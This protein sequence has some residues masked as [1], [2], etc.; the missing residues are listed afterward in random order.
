MRTV[1]V[2]ADRIPG[3]VERFSERHGPS[4][5]KRI[6]GNLHV[7]AADG[8]W[9]TLS[10][11]HPLDDA[12]V[13]T[14]DT[15][16]EAW[17][18]SAA[19]VPPTAVI[20]V[21]R[22][23]FL[24]AVVDGDQVEGRAGRRHVQGRT[25]AGGW[26]Q[27]RFARRRSQQADALVDAAADYATTWILPRLPVELLVLGGDKPLVAGVLSDSRLQPLAGLTRGRTLDVG[28][29]TSATLR[30]LPKLLREVSIDV[31]DVDRDGSR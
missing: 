8:S 19:D 14:R 5:I 16:V 17:A 11:S 18:R 9:A 6:D 13:S 29:P 1:Q 25:A 20:I 3:W 23:G 26:S 15:D 27:Q 24:A 2:D 22:G 31:H 4:V 7:A 21:R 12:T 10:A 28:D 30:A